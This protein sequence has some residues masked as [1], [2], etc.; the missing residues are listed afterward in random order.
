M[1]KLITACA[2]ALTASVAVANPFA[3]ADNQ[4][5]GKI[6]LLTEP[7]PN[8]AQ[9]QRAYFWIRSG[10]TEDG[11]WRY[12]GDTIVA[13]WENQGKRRYAISDFRLVNQFSKFRTW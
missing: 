13:E 2:I 7:C 4:G 5:G 9:M 12:D 1:F 6:T 8:K 3:E 10:I 11:C